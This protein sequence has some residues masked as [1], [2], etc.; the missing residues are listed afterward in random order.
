MRL[1]RRQ[2]VLLLVVLVLAAFIGL[3][4]PTRNHDNLVF[5]G[6]D[7]VC[8]PGEEVDVSAM[9]ER[10]DRFGMRKRI[11]GVPVMFH[12]EGRF[13]GGATTDAEGIAT[14]AFAT[15]E[16]GYYE[17]EAR[18]E[19]PDLGSLRTSSLVAAMSD[20]DHILVVDVDH[21]LAA[22]PG[23]ADSLLGNYE[24]LEPVDG[25]REAL[26]NLYKD[27]QFFYL[28]ERSDRH[29]GTT[30]RWLRHYGFP[31][32]P[33]HFKVGS[34]LVR[35][36]DHRKRRLLELKQKW[37]GVQLG[38][39]DSAADAEL[40]LSCGMRAF[41]LDEDSGSSL[42]PTGADNIRDWEELVYLVRR[43]F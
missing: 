22:K 40:F 43:D 8:L 12:H 39:G 23:L 42:L 32:G 17:V 14:L 1:S 5:E 31:P 33:I 7:A 27:Y 10:R 30:E 16:P 29:I 15:S 37:P 34:F 9:L 25:A 6:F 13:L 3:G 41:I 19:S 38:I 35:G 11:P 2:I 36:T 20:D 28:T 24:N 26:E 21:T 18:I 4:S